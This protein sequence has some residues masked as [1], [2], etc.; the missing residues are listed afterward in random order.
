MYKRFQVFT[1]FAQRVRHKAYMRLNGFANI[2]WRKALG[3]LAKHGREDS[4]FLFPPVVCTYLRAI[5]NKACFV[6]FST[7]WRAHRSD[8]CWKFCVIRP[9]QDSDLPRRAALLAVRREVREEALG[10]S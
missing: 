4:H 5:P 7:K 6:P 8:H 1:S 9:F 10:D 3:K 2:A